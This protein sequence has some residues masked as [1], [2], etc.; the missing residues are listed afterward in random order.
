MLCVVRSSTVDSKRYKRDDADKIERG[1]Y[2]S[3]RFGLVRFEQRSCLDS[4]VK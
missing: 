2:T 4:L 1:E 3:Q